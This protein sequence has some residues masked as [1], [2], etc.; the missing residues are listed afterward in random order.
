VFLKL[1]ES[2][3]R[4]SVI[5]LKAAQSKNY[6]YLRFNAGYGYTQN[7]YEIASFSRQD[8]LGPNVGVTLGFNIFDGFNRTREQRN[9]RIQIENNS[10]LNDELLHSLKSDFA[11]V[12]MAYEN[13]MKLTALERENVNTAIENY[14][15]AIE[16][17]MLGDLSGIQLREAQNSLLEAEERLVQAEY[18]TKLCEISLLQISGNMVGYL[19]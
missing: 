5:D 3:K 7:R 17:Y 6:P 11:N 16:R 14:E 13:N 9:A 12:W 10:L 2:D 15:I 4:L 8:N 19:R 18:N 1:S